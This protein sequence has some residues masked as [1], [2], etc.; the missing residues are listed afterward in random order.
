MTVKRSRAS[1]ALKRW[2]LEDGRSQV[3]LARGVSEVLGR[4]AEPVNQSTI[5]SWASGRYQPGGAGM[6]AIQRLTGI[7]I[8]DWIIPVD[9]SEPALGAVASADDSGGFSVVTDKPKKRSK[10][11]A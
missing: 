11:A 4:E 6:L 5:S 10:P 8:D 3:E 7:P 2:L 9:E 1:V